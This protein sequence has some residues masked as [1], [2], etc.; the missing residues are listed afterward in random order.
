MKTVSRRASGAQRTSPADVVTAPSS[1]LA[2]TGSGPALG[3]TA[4]IG[5]VLVLA[6]LALFAAAESARRL[7]RIPVSADWSHLRSRAGRGGGD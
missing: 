5:A 6:G 4:Y 7:R 2:F 1:A 3:W